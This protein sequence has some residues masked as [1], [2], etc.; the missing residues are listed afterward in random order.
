MSTPTAFA[1]WLTEMAAKYGK[2]PEPIPENAVCSNEPVRPSEMISGSSGVQYSYGDNTNETAAE[3]Q[4]F[5]TGSRENAEANDH[6]QAGGAYNGEGSH[7][8]QSPSLTAGGFVF[9]YGIGF[10]CGNYKS[11]NDLKDVS[12][13]GKPKSAY[14]SAFKGMDKSHQYKDPVSADILKKI[15]EWVKVLSDDLQDC[16]NGEL[17][18][19][20]QGHGANGSFYGVDEVEI[21]ASQ[22]LSLAKQAEASRVSITYV[23]DACFSGAAVPAFQDHAGDRIDGAI[24]ENVA[25]AGQVCS[26]ENEANAEIL[27]T[28]MAHA[29]S[30]IQFSGAVSTLGDKLHA[31]VSS[32]KSSI[33]KANIDAALKL[34]D[35]I[36][37]L[38]A[39]M[40]TQFLHNKDVGSTPEMNLD[41]IETAFADVLTFL[42][43]IAAKPTSDPAFW[44]QAVLGML[45][46]SKTGPLDL[47]A[48]PAAIGKFQDKISDGANHIIKLAETA[49]QG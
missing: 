35:E 20:F 22:L 26:E 28:W 3:G 39:A 45:G 46:L 48:W 1:E 4:D 49:A 42:R 36:I 24:E 38:I 47:K 15:A 37:A 7:P 13:Y 8:M 23:M 21:K 17:V 43:G 11:W 5:G 6:N 27:R 25:G 40:E 44:G 31:T 19:S 29:R 33:T 16:G 10:L 30:L 34:N 14:L 12:D 9:R 18:V 41:G 32:L 2:T